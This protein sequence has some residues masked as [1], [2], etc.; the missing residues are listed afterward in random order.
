MD[1]YHGGGQW[2]AKFF[3]SHFQ[4]KTWKTNLSTL[5]QHH[6]AL[7]KFNKFEMYVVETFHTQFETQHFNFR[8]LAT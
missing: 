7:E 4:Q 2:N 3:P 8:S 5:I 6:F 1:F